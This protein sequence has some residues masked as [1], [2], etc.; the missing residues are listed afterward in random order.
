MM[1]QR[2][3]IKNRCASSS[4]HALFIGDSCLSRDHRK[5]NLTCFVFKT[6]WK[7]NAPVEITAQRKFALVL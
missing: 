7:H 6:R 4:T 2:R 1:A 3:N 5:F